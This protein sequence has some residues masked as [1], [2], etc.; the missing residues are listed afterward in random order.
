VLSA[1]DAG[2]PM[3]DIVNTERGAVAAGFTDGG[4]LFTR[5][6]ALTRPAPSMVTHELRGIVGSRDPSVRAWA[7]SIVAARTVHGCKE[8]EA[9]FGAVGSGH[10][11]HE[12]VAGIP[13][14]LTACGCAVDPDNVHDLMWMV[15]APVDHP[16]Q[17]VVEVT[18]ADSDDESA[19]AITGAT[20]TDAAP[21]VIAAKGQRIRFMRP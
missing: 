20:W 16:P 17:S 5:P 18:F 8:L 2:A 7:L 4:I 13:G 19:R 10:G 3:D 11:G 1:I 12:L 15:L 14:A 21:A 6:T 9:V